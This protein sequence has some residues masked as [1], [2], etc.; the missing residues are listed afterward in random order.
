MSYECKKGYKL[1]IE[2]IHNTKLLTELLKLSCHLWFLKN[3]KLNYP[4]RQWKK[5]GKVEKNK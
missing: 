4:L 3:C 5:F 1:T 2:K